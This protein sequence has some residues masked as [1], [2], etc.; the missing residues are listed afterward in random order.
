MEVS[1]TTPSSMNT[2]SQEILHQSSF[3]LSN[4]HLIYPASIYPRIISTIQLPINKEFF[5]QSS[6]YFTNIILTYTASI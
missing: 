3:Y 2:V 5:H 6:F 1:P 4:I